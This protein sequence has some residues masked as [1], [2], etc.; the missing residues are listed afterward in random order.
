MAV[1]N[2]LFPCTVDTYMPAFLIGSNNAQKNIC[3]VYFSISAYNSINDIVNAQVTVTN[4]NNN[5]S[6]L[7]KKKY[8]C[9]IM[10]TNIKLDTERT[11]D[12]KYYIEINSSD[13]EEGFQINQYY[14]VQIRFTG[15][16]AT[17]LP[18]NIG[19]P[20]QN[21]NE[22]DQKYTD[23]QSIDSWLVANL[24]HFSEW[25]TVCLVRGISSP[26]LSMGGFDVSANLTLWAL[27]NVN[28][29]GSLNF[30]DSTETDTLKSYRIKLYNIDNELLSDSGILYTSAYTNIN[31]FN[32]TF[33]YAFNEGEDYYFT[34]E[35]ETANMYSDIATY[36]FIVI[37][38]NI[39]ILNASLTAELDENN[40]AIVLHVKGK[41]SSNFI[42]NI[43][44]RRSSSE[45]NFTIWEDMHTQIFD[46]NTILDYTWTD[47][48][49]KSG[50]YY[51]YIVQK[52]TSSGSRGVAVHA[53]NEPFMMLFDDMYLT[54]GDA[55]LKIRFDP[56]V[57][58][59]RRSVSEARTETVGSKYPF[60]KRNGYI[61]YRQFPIGGTITCL[62]DTSHLLTSREEIFKDSL[63][64]YND[65]NK[66]NK[67]NQYND[68]TYEREFR[69]KV[70][71]FLYAN[72]V[73]LFRSATEGNILIKLMDIN[74]TPNA[75]LGRRIYSFTATAYEIDECNI[76]NFDKYNILSL[77]TYSTLLRF[78]QDYIGE[79]GETIPANKEF[80]DILYEKYNPYAKEKYIIQIDNLDYLRIEMEMKPYLIKEGANGPY[81]LDDKG[82]SKEEPQ[83][84]ILGYLVYIN[85]LPV[86]INP[87]G[88]Y[89]L[90]NKDTAITS[91]KFPIN[92]KAHLDYHINI[93]QV[94]DESLIVKTNSFYKTVGQLWGT[95]GPNI[96]LYQQIW[97]KYY[98]KYSNYYQALL[99]LDSVRVESDPGT[100][101]YIKE[102]SDSDFERH[103]IGT[104]GELNFDSEDATIEGLF[105][106]GKHLEPA[107]AAEL[108]RD[109]LP[110][111]K[112]IDTGITLD[113]YLINTTTL[114][115][116]GVYTI[117]DDYLDVLD[118]DTGWRSFKSKLQWAEEDTASVNPENIE[119]NF[120]DYILLLEKDIDII[121]DD[122][123]IAINYTDIEQ[124]DA[125]WTGV[126]YADG[127]LDTTIPT[128]LN[129]DNPD[130]IIATGQS[131]YYDQYSFKSKK[132][133][134][135]NYTASAN[136]DIISGPNNAKIMELDQIYDD[137]YHLILNKEVNRL[138]A[139]LLGRI[140]D[141]ANSRYI[142]RDGKWWL[143]T[144]DND[145][146]C[147]VEALIDYT[148]EII[149]GRYR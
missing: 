122:G 80:F 146:L 143:F 70:M 135:N 91:L 125:I 57:S 123:G 24:S 113:R 43:T 128:Q 102:S 83:D 58:S 47:Y 104:T 49:I 53:E 29:I 59:F 77:G 63:E 46:T 9:E 116:N 115:N 92:T 50:V 105:F 137:Y 94:E 78:S 120:P 136:P 103:V 141:E 22:A 12:D 111:N 112:F 98:E 114:I 16:G 38:E 23:A 110:E 1:N 85:E 14:K 108:E 52:R 18:M 3:R 19:I 93:R 54:G 131:K 142:W 62:M 64:N 76:K 69:E 42:G 97:N 25:S 5:L 75:T 95:F 139:L 28:V 101:F 79:Y 88:I 44:I 6:S 148:S 84:A 8:P 149:K 65:F 17:E 124:Y 117:A 21:W 56:S 71:D 147:P 72:E 138:Y 74:F 118:T 127:T 126:I 2:I 32:Y 145:L 41:D 133:W 107:T 87:E 31:E 73:R 81:I 99:S 129:E 7:D 35:Y 134:P 68:W 33:E 86:I 121:D 10:I 100:A 34:F 82:Q 36:S 37:Q 119:S 109:A 48:T 15:T 13:I 39:D 40:A 60:I 51:K 61:N 106:L 45:T 130:D 67:I 27:D 20:P 96:S 55:Q 132:Q 11:T 144:S 66:K 30:S 4:Q 89:E 26:S 140:I 90:K